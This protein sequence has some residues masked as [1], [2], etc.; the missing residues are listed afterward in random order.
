MGKGSVKFPNLRGDHVLERRVGK[1]W[2]IVALLA[3]H[4]VFFCSFQKKMD[5]AQFDM[6][7]SYEQKGEWV[8]S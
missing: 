5:K 3:H 1:V 8:I 6:R 7:V 2:L 4:G